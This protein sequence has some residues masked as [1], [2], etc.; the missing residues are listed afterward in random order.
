ML[1]QD[2]IPAVQLLRGLALISSKEMSAFDM[3]LLS[4]FFPNFWGEILI[5]QASILLPR[6]FLIFIL[7]LPMLYKY[8][9]W[10]LLS[11]LGL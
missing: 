8:N 4:V 9:V 2:S 10:A 11:F 3:P 6:I 5:P 1:Q 7:M